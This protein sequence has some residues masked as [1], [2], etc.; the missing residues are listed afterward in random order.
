MSLRWLGSRLMFL[1]ANDALDADNADDAAV[2]ADVAIVS[3]ESAW[4]FELKN[5]LKGWGMQFMSTMLSP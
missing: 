3:I 5:S 4:D 1:G 2:D